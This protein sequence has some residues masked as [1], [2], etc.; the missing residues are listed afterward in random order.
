MRFRE[1]VHAVDLFG[2]KSRVVCEAALCLS[3]DQSLTSRQ[4]IGAF[5]STEFRFQI[6]FLIVSDRKRT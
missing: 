4:T 2:K 6:N 1:I 5:S 3:T